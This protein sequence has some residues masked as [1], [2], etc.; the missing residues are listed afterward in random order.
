MRSTIQQQLQRWFD[1][2][3]GRFLRDSENQ[4]LS[5]L[6]PHLFG[7]YFVQLGGPANHEWLANCRIPVR[8]H[9]SEN[10]PCD[11]SGDCIKADFTALPLA[12]DSVDVVLLP[13]LLEFATEPQLIFNQVY[14]S[15]IPG[16]YLVILGFHPWSLWGLLRLFK[17]HTQMP[18]K[19][20][21][22]SSYRIRS[23]L[24]KEGF[25]I[26]DHETLFF[27]PPL[28]RAR[29]LRRLFVMEPIG[30][31]L[32]PYLGGVYLIVAKKRVAAATPIRQVS[33][34]RKKVKIPQGVAQPTARVR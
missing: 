20:K 30:Q 3:P 22:Y 14:Q 17:K 34:R 25:S 13:H 10:C 23:W 24:S 1:Q 4:L 6:L 26:E 29:W 19:G 18:W 5:R 21:F 12:N 33:P 31:L 28:R 9:I 32:W 27:R 7:Y 2:V 16:G 11:F 8:V 15:L